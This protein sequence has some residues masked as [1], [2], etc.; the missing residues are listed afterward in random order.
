MRSHVSTA[1]LAALG[2]AWGMGSGAA[3]AVDFDW[4]G[5]LE[6]D[7]RVSVPGKDDGQQGAKR[8][9]FLRSDS[10]ARLRV[11]LGGD[12]AAGVADVAL[13]WTGFAQ[14]KTLGDLVPRE[15]V[16]PVRLESD[17]L[18]V[19]FYDVLLDGLDLR[20]GR[21]IVKWGSADRFHPIDVLNPYDYEDRIKFSESIATEMV[22]ARWTAPWSVYTEDRTIFDDFQLT[23]AFVPFFHPAQLPPF[24]LGAFE[25]PSL[26]AQVA[27][28]PTLQAL[29]QLQRAFADAGGSLDTHVRVHP[30]EPTLDNAQV[31]IQLGW[32]LLGVDMHAMYYR[33]YDDLPR[34]ERVRTGTL[35]VAFDPA[36]TDEMLDLI[37]KLDLTGVEVQSDIDVTYPRVQVAGGDVATSLDFLGGLGLWAEFAWVWHDALYR[38]MDLGGV[39]IVERDLPAEGYWKLTAGTDYSF[40]SLVYANLQYVHGFVDEFG[41]REQRDYLVGGTDWKF[42]RER[43]VLRLFGIYQIQD[44]SYELL[45]QLFVRWWPGAELSL[46]ALLAGGA[47]DS[48]FGSRLTGPNMVFLTARY[49]Y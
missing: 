8:F 28:G 17:A 5:Y 24:S 29:V 1:C 46:G 19:D 49:S 11:G 6:N 10:W 48:K 36:K 23:V 18:Y 12:R 21:Q 9:R 2:L 16:D 41:A 20:I 34:A 43:I 38:Q 45:P 4:R 26:F 25:D 3:R 22:V 40:G 32:T 39:R 27:R 30:P 44:R 42:A 14:T 31:G 37:Q 15:R 7:L 35:P 13:V 47:A 33:G